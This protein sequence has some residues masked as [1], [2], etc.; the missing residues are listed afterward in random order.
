MLSPLHIV[1]RRG[2]EMCPVCWW[3]DDGQDDVDEDVVICGPNGSLSLKQGRMN[4]ESFGVGKNDSLKRRGVL[5]IQKQE[6]V[7]LRCD[8]R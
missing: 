1:G 7:S 5:W 8:C 3:E 2:V 6:R 4:Y